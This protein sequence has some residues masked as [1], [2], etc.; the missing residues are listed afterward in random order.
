MRKKMYK[1]KKHWVV[2]SAAALTV[3]GTSGLVAADEQSYPQ[4]GA[5]RELA[6]VSTDSSATATD[7]QDSSKSVENTSQPASTSTLDDSSQ[8]G[9]NQSVDEASQSSQ[10]EPAGSETI[11]DWET[12]N[13]SASEVQSSQRDSEAQIQAPASTNQVDPSDEEDQLQVADQTINGGSRV[14]RASAG[15][16][17]A[18]TTAAGQSSSE[19]T[20]ASVSGK[21]LIIHYNRSIA[22]NEALYFAVWTEQNDQ[23]D[24]VWYQANAQGAAYIDL[25]KHR[26]Y[27]KYI[28]HTYSV[29]NGQNIG[30]NATSIM[31]NP[32]KIS[33]KIEATSNGDYKLTVGN[34]SSDITEVFV[35]VWSDKNDQDDMI[36]Y[37]ADKVNANTYSLTIKPA[38]HHNDFGHYSVHIYGQSSITGGLIGLSATPGFERKETASSSKVAPQNKVRASLGANGI[39]L[40]LDTNEAADLSNIYFAVW[41]QVGDQDDIH[42]YPA[43]GSLSALAPY[44]NHSGYGT[45]HIHTYANKNGK[46]VGI[47]TTSIEVPSPSASAKISKQDDAT[48]NVKID[49]VPSYITSVLVPVWTQKNGQD[50]IVWYPASKQSDGSYSATIKLKDHN[51]ESG[52]YLVHLY[53]YSS[54]EGGRLVGLGATDFTVTATVTPAVVWPSVADH[55]PAAGSLRVVLN[56]TDTSKKAKSMDVAVWS[57]ENQANIHWYSADVQNGKASVQV[58]EQY[59]GMISGSYTIHVYVN[60]QDGSRTG[61]NLGQYDLNKERANG[62]FIDVSSYNYNISVDSYRALKSRGITG[63]VVKLTEGNSYINPY[64]AS[65][66]ANAKAAGLKVSAYHFARYKNADEARSEAAYFVNVAKSYGL[67]SS[68]AMVDDIEHSDVLSNVNS[69]TPVWN[70]TMKSL[71]YNNLLYYTVARR[72]DTRG[73]SFSTSQVGIE[74][75]WIAHYVKGYSEMSE[76]EAAKYNYYNNAAAWQYTSV[77]KALGANVD[78]SIDYSGR[79]S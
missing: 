42:W 59:H 67:D 18:R 72:L 25:S 40:H 62:Y 36:W 33:S 32:P 63:V 46:F 11:S 44:S 6:S 50:D 27:G 8:E 22:S 75:M 37:H 55:N 14:L 29:I 23:D 76:D 34:V 51:F 79:L 61:F 12:D 15:A 77:S 31:V 19:V 49:K 64:A 47:N 74:N 60:Y 16:T 5:S 9:Q 58:D 30:R 13:Q 45:Y 38:N 56:E 4:T 54:L 21:T 73:G 24:M 41:S 7:T 68:T 26:F 65:Q 10:S 48:Y 2:A 3:L 28:I 52:K 69:N 71:G 43:D 35:P 57:E 53:G 39:Q 70:Q 1:A 66:I 20:S 17:V 78:Q